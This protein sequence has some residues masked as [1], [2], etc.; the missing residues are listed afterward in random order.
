MYVT[1]GIRSVA[2][3]LLLMGLYGFVHAGLQWLTYKTLQIEYDFG[4]TWLGYGVS[5]AL[6]GLALA[7]G[8]NRLTRWLVPVQKRECPQ[9]GYAL[10][11]L[12]SDSCPECGYR[13]GGQ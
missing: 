10:K 13:L 5:Y 4:F 3:I 12:K 7:I 9:C 2:V 6:I 1:L 8:S 11:S